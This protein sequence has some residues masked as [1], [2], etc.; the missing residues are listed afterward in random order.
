MQLCGPRRSRLEK[1][2]SAKPSQ[3]D[4]ACGSTNANSPCGR[5]NAR[6]ECLRANDKLP[7]FLRMTLTA[8]KLTGRVFGRSG[9]A[10]P[11]RSDHPATLFGT[12]T[13]N[14]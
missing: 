1:A 2:I 8:E 7:G 4:R 12:F 11:R 6:R 9:A 10:Q 14:R 3:S 13:V 5:G